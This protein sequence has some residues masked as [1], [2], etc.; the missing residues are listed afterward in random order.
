MAKKMHN[1]A[2]PVKDKG[3]FAPIVLNVGLGRVGHQQH[4]GGTGFHNSRKKNSRGQQQRK[5]IADYS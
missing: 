5:A 2:A 1:T 3:L 4:T